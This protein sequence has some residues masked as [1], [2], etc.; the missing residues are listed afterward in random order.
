MADIDM[1]EY[2]T[3]AAA[4][5]A[6]A[7]DGIPASTNK[8]LNIG[9][10]SESG[11]GTQ[12]KTGP[13]AS[14]TVNGVHDGSDYYARTNTG[15]AQA[16]I[17]IVYNPFSSTINATEIKIWGY[18]GSTSGS[19]LVEFYYASAWHTAY[20]GSPV[21]VPYS[22]ISS[23]GTWN[24]VEQ[25]RITCTGT[26]ALASYAGLYE[27]EVHGYNYVLQSYS[28]STIKSQGSY[29]LKGVA[30]ITDSLNKT[31]TKRVF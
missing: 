5:A 11:V 29:S 26:G 9:I 24:N 16:S 10:E 18:N 30:A 13:D 27:V 12:V 14:S 20:S 1:M 7:T 15:G 31:L 22:P 23:S 28:E 25:V 21:G 3:D 4:Q 8:L 17:Y 2:A 6:Y 19:I